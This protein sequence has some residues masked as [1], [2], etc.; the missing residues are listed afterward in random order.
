MRTRKLA[1]TGSAFAVLVV[2]AC[3]GAGDAPTVSLPSHTHGLP[4]C[5]DA[6]VQPPAAPIPG[7]RSGGTM[8]VLSAGG[9]LAPMDPTDNYLLASAS[10]ESGLVIRSLTQYV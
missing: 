1:I 2:A 4:E 7:A 5:C 6:R 8:T 10:I 3:S 9:D